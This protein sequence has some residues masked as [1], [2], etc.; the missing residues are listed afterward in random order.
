MF[1]RLH[2]DDLR[3]GANDKQTRTDENFSRRI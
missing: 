2:N 1:L 3:Q